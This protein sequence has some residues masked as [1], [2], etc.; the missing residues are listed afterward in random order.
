MAFFLSEKCFEND[1]YSRTS[2]EILNV[3]CR[4]KVDT[5]H[6][7]IQS[8]LCSKVFVLKLCGELLYVTQTLSLPFGS[9]Y[10]TFLLLRVS[11]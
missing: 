6:K 2:L 1:A 4:L 10:S 9:L 11:L 7:I 5:S 8:F 3:A